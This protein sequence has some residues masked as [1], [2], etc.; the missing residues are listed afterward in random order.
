MKKFL[1][2]GGKI[3]IEGVCASHFQTL[4][5]L[6]FMPLITVL[7]CCRQEKRSLYERVMKGRERTPID[8]LSQHFFYVSHFLSTLYISISF[9]HDCWILLYLVKNY[10]KNVSYKLCFGIFFTMNNAFKL[11]TI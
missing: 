4:S 6:S 3:V 7:W 9:F 1:I 11:S 8:F 10:N 5:K 2:E